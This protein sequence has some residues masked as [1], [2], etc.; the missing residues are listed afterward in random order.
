MSIDIF[1]INTVIIYKKIN[2]YF[3]NKYALFILLPEI[4]KNDAKNMKM[5]SIELAIIVF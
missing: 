3:G 2:R 4:Y 5:Y 1:Y